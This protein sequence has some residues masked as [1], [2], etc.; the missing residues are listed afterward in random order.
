V[1]ETKE[2]HHP[3]TPNVGEGR[4]KKASDQ[5]RNAHTIMNQLVARTLAKTSGI[6]SNLVKQAFPNRIGNTSG[7]SSSSPSPEFAIHQV[8]YERFFF[9]HTCRL[10]KIL[11]P[12]GSATRTVLD[13]L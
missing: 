5:Q 7:G 10:G 2:Q 12:S 11:V 13:G 4:L 9:L 3:K 8:C 6:V 1:A